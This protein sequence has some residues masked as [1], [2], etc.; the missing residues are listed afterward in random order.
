VEDVHIYDTHQQGQAWTE[1]FAKLAT[2]S[3]D[4]HYND[5]YLSQVEVELSIIDQLSV[6]NKHPKPFTTMEVTDAIAKL[7]TGKAA[8]EDGLCAEGLKLVA[9]EVAPVLTVLFNQMLELKCVPSGLKRGILTPIGKKDKSQLHPD[10]YRGITVTATIGKVL[11]HIIL[12]RVQPHQTQHQSQQQVGFTE[13]LSPSMAALVVTEAIAEADS[14]GS[15]LYICTLDAKKAFDTVCHSSLLR[16]LYLEGVELGTWSL[17]KESYRNMTTKVKW[18]DEIGEEFI[19]RQGVRQG[20]V[21]SPSLYKTY[22]NNLLLSVE[23][24][25][26]GFHI[27]PFSVASPGNI[28]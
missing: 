19:V 21:M 7:N 11:E 3:S 13:K 9:P 16:K 18:K 4:S 25:G 8:D 28:E 6:N 23:D 5:E 17:I 22:I 26:R 27:G 20:G 15:P 2:P 10:N 24:T 14:M 1:H 12:K